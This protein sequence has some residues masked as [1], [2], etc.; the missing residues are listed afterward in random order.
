MSQFGAAVIVYPRD[1]ALRRRHFDERHSLTAH[2]ML[3]TRLKRTTPKTN[4]KTVINKE[5]SWR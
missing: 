4:A 1:L 3:W 5:L 2:R